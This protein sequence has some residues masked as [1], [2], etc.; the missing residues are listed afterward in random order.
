MTLV[1]GVALGSAWPLTLLSCAQMPIGA[2]RTANAINLARLRWIMEI[3]SRQAQKIEEHFIKSGLVNCLE[4]DNIFATKV[5][6][7]QGLF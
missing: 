1:C 4:L 2:S 3:G 7:E 6:Y 5:S